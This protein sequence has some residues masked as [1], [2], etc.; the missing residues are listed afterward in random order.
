MT[1]AVPPGPK[2]IRALWWWVRLVRDPLATF[3]ALRREYGDALQ[4]PVPLSRTQMFHLLSRPEHAEHVLVQH[5]DNYVKAI[6]YRPLR[7]FLGDGLL[8]AEGARW[9]RH[10]RL[11]QPVFSHRH[12]QPFG[13]VIV[14][15]A[16]N[17]FAQWTSGITIDVADEM[18]TLTMDVIGR[19]LF[20]SELAGDAA[21]VGRAVTRLQN[22]I[23]IAAM[24]PTSLSAERL[25]VIG[26]RVIP[27]LSRASQ[28]LDSL[29]AR[30]IDVRIAASHDEPSDLL[31]LLLAAEEDEEPLSRAEI[32]DEVRTLVV[33]GHESTA[34]ALTWTL[35]LLSRN[36]AAYDRLVTEVDDVLGGRDPHASDIDALPWTKAV[37]AEALRLYPPAWQIGREAVRD[38]EICGIAVAAGDMVG[39]S[40]YL[41]HRHPEFWPDP[42]VFDPRRFLPD[43]SST[44]PRYAYLPFGG[45][46]RI[47]VGAGLAQLEAVLALAVLGQT[48]RVE[49]V[50][51]APLRMRADVTLHPSGP[52][53]ATVTP[54]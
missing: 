49:L 31:D 26:P 1:A 40:P 21:P 42:D 46:H 51:T 5:Q 33:A 38:D 22:S 15:A 8:T 43:G 39:I 54:V 19:V 20:G 23:A 30:I 14:A 9:Q 3:V 48:A 13:P 6:T 16:R 2:G 11:V 36:P 24:L 10:R 29:I 44:R 37:L 52:V 4:V 28:T 45:G 17:R 27:G 25:R 50:P 47:C 41:L 34:N 32:Q 53:P 35:T 18:R 7:A 12:I